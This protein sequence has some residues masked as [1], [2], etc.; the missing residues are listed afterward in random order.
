M[1]AAVEAAAMEAAAAEMSAAAE[2]AA[3]EGVHASTLRMIMHNLAAFRAAHPVG[4][5]EVTAVHIVKS[6]LIVPGAAE[7]GMPGQPAG[8]APAALEAASAM[9]RSIAVTPKIT[10]HLG[11]GPIPRCGMI[12]ALELFGHP[13]IVVRHAPTMVGVVMPGVPV[14]AVMVAVPIMAAVAVVVVVMM[15]VAVVVIMII[16]IVMVHI[17]M[18]VVMIPV[19]IAPQSIAGGHAETE[20][21]NAAGHIIRR[22]P[23]IGRI[24]RVWPG[25]V[26]HCGI[27]HR[28]VNRVR[29]GGLNNNDL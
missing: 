11:P 10:I 5:G 24:G 1:S 15:A 13:V 29:L 12:A 21:N 28:H 27:V 17:N 25:P 23:V 26:N 3:M 22:I 19:H 2:A 20:G 18:N 4:M 7:L 6:A 8:L 9:Q 14:A 16:V